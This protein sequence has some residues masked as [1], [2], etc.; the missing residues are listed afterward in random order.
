MSTAT[1]NGSEWARIF[2]DF[3]D[4]HRDSKDKKLKY[5]AVFNAAMDA[6]INCPDVPLMWRLLA[7]IWRTSWGNSSDF[8]VE[9]I[10]GRP[11]GQRGLAERLEVDARR[12]NDSISDLRLL[13]FVEPAT[14]HRVYPIDDPSQV[15]PPNENPEDPKNPPPNGLFKEFCEEWKIRSLADFQELE[16]AEDTVSR[17][18]KIRLGQ[19][20]EWKRA[21]TSGGPTLYTNT[22]T[23]NSEPEPVGRSVELPPPPAAEQPSYLPTAPSSAEIIPDPRRD[24]A[25]REVIEVVEDVAVPV[26]GESPTDAQYLEIF[27]KLAGASPEQL[28]QR[29]EAKKARG[30]LHSVMVL[31]YLAEDCARSKNWRPP[32]TKAAAAPGRKNFID[33]VDEAFIRRINEWGLRR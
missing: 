6:F 31:P 4:R 25:F 22:E 28:R 11:I 24:P 2:S 15:E 26:I 23:V 30:E 12:I 3:H 19:Y 33:S 29:I 20:R 9:E 5:V 16:S 21:R 1:T 13:N 18:K 14:G 7:L 32:K 17:L 10:G 8:C 27:A